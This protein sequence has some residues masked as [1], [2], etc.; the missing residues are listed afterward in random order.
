MSRV[1]ISFLLFVYCGCSPKKESSKFIGFW[2]NEGA[3]EKWMKIQ[4]LV[5]DDNKFTYWFFS[6]RKSLDQPEMPLEG[7]YEIKGDR[8]LLSID[9]NLHLYSREFII[10]DEN[11]KQVLL[12]AHQLNNW[13]NNRKVDCHPLYKQKKFEDPMFLKSIENFLDHPTAVVQKTGRYRDLQKISKN[14]KCVVEERGDDFVNIKVYEDHETHTV[15]LET[16]KVTK[17]RISTLGADE[18]FK[19]K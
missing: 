3:S 17:D 15:K 13:E 16:F 7:T 11:G 4:I 9:E 10:T 18:N 19:E 2:K 8:I 6:D 1:L 5:D 12:A 14:L